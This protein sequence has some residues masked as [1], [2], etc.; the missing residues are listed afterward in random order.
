VDLVL[1]EALDV[2]CNACAI[3]KLGDN[4]RLVA[5]EA[6]DYVRYYRG[7]LPGLLNIRVLLLEERLFRD[8]RAL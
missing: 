8:T 4:S 5:L 7:I 2:L 3:V 6:V 1:I